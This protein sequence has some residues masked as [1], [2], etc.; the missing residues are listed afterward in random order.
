M[1][2]KNSDTSLFMGPRLLTYTDTDYAVIFVAKKLSLSPGVTMIGHI[3]RMLESSLIS[4][5]VPKS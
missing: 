1:Q 3:K 4:L 2:I 5:R